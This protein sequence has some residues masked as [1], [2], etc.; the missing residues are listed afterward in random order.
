M[1]ISTA[2]Q[3]HSGFLVAAL[4]AASGLL[5]AVLFFGPLAHLERLASGLTAFDIRPRSYTLTVREETILAE[6]AEIG[7]R[8]MTRGRELSPLD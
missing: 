7:E 6:L 8:A 1:P 5:W 3:F 4:L 2:K